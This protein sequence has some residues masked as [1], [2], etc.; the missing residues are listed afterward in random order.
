[1]VDLTSSLGGALIYE[2]RLP[3]RWRLSET[4]AESGQISRLN[5][6]NEEI[7]FNILELEK[8]QTE[9]TDEDP[10]RNSTELA[11]I[12]FKLNLLLDLVTQVY[13]RELEMPPDT[14]VLLGTSELCFSTRDVLKQGDYLLVD[15]FL[16]QRF[17]RPVTL[18]GRVHV[19]ERLD[20]GDF[21]IGLVLEHLS[22]PLNDLLERFIFMKHRRMIA[23]ARRQHKS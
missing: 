14:A 20:A 1:M 3:L 6:N 8:R 18:S 13:T 15:V 17:P 21:R 23:S 7:L 9:I 19:V 12:D 10:E 11:R 22:A 2:D 5:Q 4:P 16:S